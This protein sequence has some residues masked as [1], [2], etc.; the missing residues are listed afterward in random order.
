MMHKINKKDKKNRSR[1]LDQDLWTFIHVPKTAGR[2]I[3]K[4]LKGKVNYYGHAPLSVIL[5]RHDKVKSFAVVRHPLDRFVSAYNFNQLGKPEEINDYIEV[6][7][8]N[9]FYRFV[10]KHHNHFYTQEHFVCH[11]GK[12]AVDEIFKFEQIDIAFDWI[13]EH[14]KVQLERKE[15]N[16][17]YRRILNR[18][19]REF[20][21]FIYKR[22]FDLFNYLPF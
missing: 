3:S 12:M 13:F 11:N 5:E 16:T 4:S 6:L 9:P 8:K 15:V 21:T 10:C 7:T 22:D 19:S 2:F 14:T 17:D 20:L 1:R 18:K